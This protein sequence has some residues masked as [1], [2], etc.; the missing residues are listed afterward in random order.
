MEYLPSDHVRLSEDGREVVYLDQTLLPGKEEFKS[1]SDIKDMYDAIAGL[2]VRG[3]PCIGVFAAYAMYVASLKHAEQDYAD[4]KESFHRDGEYLNSSRPTAVNLSWAIGR[5]EKLVDNSSAVGV[6]RIITLLKKE[7]EDIHS[8]DISLCRRIGEN[9]LEL[10]KDGAALLTHC[11][12]GALATTRY[13]TQ[14]AAVYIG[15]E[16]GMSFKLYVDETRP[17]LQGAR[18]T[19]YELMRAGVDT[20][21]LC[22]NMAGEL[23]K[24]GK[25]DAVIVG[26]DRIAANGDTANKIGT[27]ALSVLADYYHVPF[28]VFAPY[29]TIDMSTA[30]GKDIV[31]EQRAPE[32]LTEKYYVHRMAPQGVKVFNPAF[33]V[34]SNELISAIIT[35]RGILRK[36][37]DRALKEIYK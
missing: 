27:S 37:Y 25:I 34:T 32:E 31:I 15:M 6:D 26:A 30:S 22:D 8:E 11:N 3:A 9:A 28:Y 24:A 13:G 5:M 21:L 20:T 2:E 18:L 19:A 4:F 35:D 10:I 14:L 33:D 36:P 16:R 23:M 7:A 12:A 29:S 1:V 17:L